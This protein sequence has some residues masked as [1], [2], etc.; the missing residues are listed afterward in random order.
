MSKPCVYCGD[1]GVEVHA[2]EN[3]EG[4]VEAETR[5]CLCDRGV[6]LSILLD[7]AVNKGDTDEV[8]KSLPGDL[9]STTGNNG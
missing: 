9:P 1:T 4:F 5:F 8:I 3:D 2:W 7:T 6:T